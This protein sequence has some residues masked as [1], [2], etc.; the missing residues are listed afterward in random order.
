MG[1]SVGNYAKI[2][3]VK[4]VKENYTVAKLSFSKKNK[5]TNEY[6]PNFIGVAR[7]VGNA[8]LQKPMVDQKIKITACDVTNCYVK[9]GKVEFPERPQYVV[10]SYELQDSNGTTPQPIRVEQVMAIANDDDLPF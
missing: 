6:E 3:E 9:D 7:F 5:A 2:K 8:H 4:E 10:F 1:F